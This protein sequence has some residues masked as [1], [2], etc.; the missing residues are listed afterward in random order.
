MSRARAAC[1]C[2]ALQFQH[3]QGQ[4]VNLL[5]VAMEESLDLGLRQV[6]AIAFKNLVRKEWD[7]SGAH[8]CPAGG[9]RQHPRKVLPACLGRNPACMHQSR[10]PARHY[11]I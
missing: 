3:E 10:Q 1:V 8:A 9:S 2:L 6:A 5:R 4:L 7:P 11:A